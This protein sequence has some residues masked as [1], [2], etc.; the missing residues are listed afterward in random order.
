MNNDIYKYINKKYSKYKLPKDTQTMKQICLPKKFE[1]QP[2]QEFLADYFIDENA[3][4]G[5]LVYHKIGAGKTCT[6]INIA[7]K[8]M[9][10][11]KNY[12]I[13]IVLPAALIGNFRNELRSE[14]PAEKYISKSERNELKM[15][16]PDDTK[17]KKIINKSDEKINKNYTIYSYHKFV[18]L[19]KRNKLNLNNSLLIIDEIQNMVSL[20]GSFYRNLLKQ[21]N[22]KNIRII[23]LSATPM[24]DKP[25]EIALTLNL[26]K[27]AKPLPIGTDFDK[28]FLS[29]KKV[30]NLISYKVKN[31]T[32]LKNKMI[33]MISYY[34][35]APPQAFPT[36]IFRVVKCKME[37]FQY[38]SYL[39]VLNQEDRFYKNKNIDILDLPNNFYIGPR[40]IL[41][42][43]FPNKS[44]G[45]NGYR[46]FTKD[47]LNL[48]KINTYSSKFYKMLKKIKSVKGTVFVYSNF[49]EYGGLRTFAK[50]LIANGY[51]DYKDNGEGNKRFA[52]WSGDETHEMKEEIKF[53]FNQKSNSDGSKLKI[54]MGS[55]SIKEGVSLLRVQQ[56]HI[57][58]PYWNYSRILQ[59]IGRASRHCSHKD[60]PPDKRQVKIYLYLSTYPNK[61]TIDQYIWDLAKEKNKIISQFETILKEVAI[62]CTLF[63]N[64]NVYKDEKPLKCLK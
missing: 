58:E 38:K 50:F 40:M 49:K 21:I 22:V 3:P 20:T 43:S 5:L 17:F 64:R 10:K 52:I 25:N 41:N 14:C 35:G 51:K 33:N 6:A 46:S 45:I 60:M 47:L 26:L 32:K 23:L 42:V 36:E 53:I 39:S 28:Q 4:T 1:F 62:D 13:V 24:F 18:D 61:Y 59:I 48:E 30:D 55:P 57:M 54:I 19:S 27:P 8:F 37:S 44:F 56:V 2:S 16:K 34:R 12:K 9:T 11:F 29:V 15:L 63:Y 31:I 7:E